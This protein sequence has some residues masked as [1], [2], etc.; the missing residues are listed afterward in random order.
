MP[1]DGSQQKEQT[2]GTVRGED[3]HRGTVRR[4][5]R[6]RVMVRGEDQQSDREG[7]SPARCHAL[8]GPQR[9]QAARSAS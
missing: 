6:H 8:R 7:G 5:D 3:R 9:A 2:R 1:G 4:E